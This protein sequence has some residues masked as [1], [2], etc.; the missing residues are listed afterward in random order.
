[1]SNYNRGTTF[2]CPIQCLLNNFL[3]LFIQCRRSLVK[4]QNLWVLDQGSRNSDTL[5]LATGEFTALEATYLEEAWMKALL[6]GLDLT[7]I[8]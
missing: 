6:L 2:H 7:C 5:L 1:M 4:D 3:T 8:D